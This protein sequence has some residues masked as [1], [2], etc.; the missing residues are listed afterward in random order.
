MLFYIISTAAWGASSILGFFLPASLDTTDPILGTYYFGVLIWSF[1]RTK[2]V[3]SASWLA[4][5]DKAG[6]DSVYNKI[7]SIMIAMYW[8][9]ASALIFSGLVC[10]IFIC[11][12]PILLCYFRNMG[13]S[14]N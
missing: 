13:V 4:F 9:R 14:K 7:N 12:I 5:V 8:L 11:T 1:C 3:R 6:P 2:E 10:I